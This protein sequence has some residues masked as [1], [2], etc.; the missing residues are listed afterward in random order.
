MAFDS[1]VRSLAD[2]SF[3]FREKEFLEIHD[4]A[5]FPADQMVVWRG[6]G[7]EAVKSAS[8]VYFFDETRCDQYGKVAVNGAEAEVREFGFQLL[9][10]PA[11]GG[12]LEIYR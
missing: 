2:S 6:F 3:D 1:E 9:I 7:L 12:V 11:G 4:R 8:G 10:K 5:A